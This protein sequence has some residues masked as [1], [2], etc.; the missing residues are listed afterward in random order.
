MLKVIFVDHIE[1]THL[2]ARQSQ[3]F[4]QIEEGGAPTR[5]KHQVIYPIFLQGY[6]SSIHELFFE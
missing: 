4:A 3:M 2:P 1:E 5:T 6:A